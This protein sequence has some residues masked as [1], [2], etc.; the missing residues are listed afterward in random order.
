MASK[1]THHYTEMTTNNLTR[2]GK[3]V[4]V[5]KGS[6][7]NSKPVVKLV[8]PSQQA[9]E[10]AKTQ[11]KQAIKEDEHLNHHHFATPNH[12]GKSGKKCTRAPRVWKRRD[13]KKKSSK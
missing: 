7:S 3:W 10:I 13:T 4:L 5:H 12:T 8:A 1:W 2:R 9:V 11:V 6:G